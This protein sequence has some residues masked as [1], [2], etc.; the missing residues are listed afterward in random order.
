[1]FSVQLYKAKPGDALGDHSARDQTVVCCLEGICF[2]PGLLSGPILG[3]LT[4]QD[5]CGIKF[6]VIA[7]FFSVLGKE[8]GMSASYLT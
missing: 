3:L 6:R 4:A 2:N 8:Y 5:K 7:P 1:M